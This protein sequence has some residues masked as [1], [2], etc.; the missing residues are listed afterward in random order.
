MSKTY[1]IKPIVWERYRDDEE[2]RAEVAFGHLHLWRT[3]EYLGKRPWAYG[4]Y[5][6][7]C[8][9][10]EDVSPEDAKLAAQSWYEQRIAGALE[11]VCK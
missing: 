5:G 8:Y 7:M 11:E 9:L 1:R 10:K 6:L 2:Y 4:C 3:K